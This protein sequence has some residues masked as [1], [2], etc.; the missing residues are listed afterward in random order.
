MIVNAGDFWGKHDA[1]GETFMSRKKRLACFV[2]ALKDSRTLDFDVKRFD[3]RLKLQKFVY[4]A[5]KCGFDLGYN[6]NLYVHGPY[7]ARLARDY[8]ALGDCTA[9]PATKLNEDF[10]SLIRNKSKRWLELASTIVM[11][12]E[13]YDN[14][15]PDEIV[16]LVKMSKPQA[17][18][19]RLYDVISELQE[20]NIM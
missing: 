9:C 8:Y 3:H 5:R 16:D 6:Y 19:D 4:L 12:S 18:N 1:L 20:H 14:A 17:K 13:R 7:S 10:T 15:D 11:V 2:K